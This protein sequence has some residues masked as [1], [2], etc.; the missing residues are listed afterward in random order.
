M[1]SGVTREIFR[2][3]GWRSEDLYGLVTSPHYPEK[4]DARSVLPAFDAPIRV[5]RDYG[6]RMYGW[7]LAPESGYYVFYTSCSDS[8][9]LY[10]SADEQE[11][12]KKKIISQMAASSHNQFDL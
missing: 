1:R 11:I 10:M 12:N 3:L 9:E 8:C 6:Q 4:P 5:G 2:G 7:F